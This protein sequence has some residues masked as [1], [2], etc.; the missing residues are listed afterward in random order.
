MNQLEQETRPL[1]YPLIRGDTEVSNL[2]AHEKEILSIWAFKTASTLSQSTGAV[3]FNIPL[4]H[5]RQL[6]IDDAVCLPQNTAVFAYSA[7]TNDFLWSLCPTWSVQIEDEIDSI[8]LPSQ[9]EHAYKIFL[10]LGRLMIAVCHWPNAKATYTFEQWGIEPIDINGSY[11]DID[12]DC[13]PFFQEE[14][15]QFMMALGVHLAPQGEIQ[16]VGRNTPCPCGSRKK[17][18]LCHGA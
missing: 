10:Q 2:H 3:Q 6:Y 1:L 15:L 8:A 17:F 5:S 4:Q 13:R 14:S 16:K 18:K 12:E 11:L 7:Q 9:H